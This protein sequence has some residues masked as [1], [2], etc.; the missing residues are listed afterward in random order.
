MNALLLD[1]LIVE[2][3]FGIGFLL[4][5]GLMMDPMGVT[6][7]EHHQPLPGCLVR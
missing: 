1:Y 4:V 6:L 5:P 7:D 2:V 3:I